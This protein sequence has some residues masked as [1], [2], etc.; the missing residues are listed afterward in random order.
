VVT[1]KQGHGDTTLRVLGGDLRYRR[2]L[3]RSPTSIR[4]HPYSLASTDHAP[5]P[6]MT[7]AAPIAMSRRLVEISAT[8]D[9]PAHNP[10]A[11]TSEPETGVHRPVSRRTAAMIA[12]TSIAA[13]AMAGAPPRCISASAMSSPPA[14]ARRRSRPAPGAPLAK[15]EKRRRRK[16]SGTGCVSAA[17][18]PSPERVDSAHPFG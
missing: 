3:R 16:T 6:S 14:A 13:D 12:T 18:R 2:S 9:R 15:V 5:G 7:S 11:A 4:R 8:E 17:A 1:R 10:A